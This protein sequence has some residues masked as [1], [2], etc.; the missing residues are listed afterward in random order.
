MP[1]PTAYYAKHWCWT[2]NNPTEQEID[3]IDALGE[4]LPEP[5]VY[6]VYGHELGES[7]TPHLQGYAA[8][9][10]RK[11]LPYIKDAISA[12][13]H[14]EGAKGTPK[15]ASS[16]CKK[17]GD[18]K[19]FGKLP[20]SQGQRNDL[21]AVAMQISQGTSMAQIAESHPT[22]LI[23]HY[24]G[25]LKTKQLYRPKRKVPH[26]EIWVLWGKTGT[27]KT[28]RVWEFADLD[29]LWVSPGVGGWFD[30]Y[31]Q[32]PAV[33]FDDFDGS[34]FK[35]SYLLKLL[36]RYVFKV[37]VKGSFVWWCP[38]TIY[39][40]SNLKPQDWYPQAS[41][42]HQKALMRRLTQFGTV[43]ECTGS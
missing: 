18:F 16:Y 24:S 36:D 31:D 8:L 15:Q 39:I 40:T 22:E 19:E 6:I 9:S 42:E 14:A 25:I 3:E 32:Q 26:P 7:G 21:K 11:R 12:R 30:G 5:F 17:D 33:L 20:N 13:I 38:N 28:R 23:R 1:T 10:V 34:W 29:E 35:L 37:P 43:Q 27:G 41:P 2:L 4:E